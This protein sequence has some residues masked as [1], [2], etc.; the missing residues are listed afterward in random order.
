[1]K[2]NNAI[3]KSFF[4]TGDYPTEAQFIDLIDSF[5]N[6]EEEDAVTGILENGNGTFTFQLLSG[7]QVTLNGATLPE[8]IP[9]ANIIGLQALLD[10]SAPGNFLAKDQDQNTTGSLSIDMAAFGDDKSFVINAQGVTVYLTMDTNGNAVM[11]NVSTNDGQN[12]KLVIKKNG[13]IEFDD[14]GTTHTLWHSGNDGNGSG[15]D[16][17][18]LDG[19]EGANLLRSDSNDSYNG[20]VLTMGFGNKSRIDFL[21]ITAPDQSIS[22]EYEAADGSLLES[23]YA[24]KIKSQNNTP[25]DKAHLEVEGG[26]Y[27]NHFSINNSSTKITETSNDAVRLTTPTGYLELGSKNTSHCHFYTDRSNFYFNKELRIDSGKIGSYNEDLILTR[28]GSS[29]DRLRVTTTYCIS[30][31]DF[32]IYGRSAQAL[33]IRASSN[34]ANTACYARFENADGSN[35]GY[36]GYGSSS[37]SNLYLYN[38]E[39][40]DSFLVLKT[41]GE[42]EFNNNVRADNFILS[43]DKRLKD[44]IKPIKSKK[45]DANWVSFDMKGEQRFGVVAQELEE[46]HPEFVKTDEEGFKSVAYIDLLVAKNAELEERIEKLENLIKN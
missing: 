44:N 19:I 5:L 2:K 37:N 28:A 14:N 4:E 36:I 23:G 39:G 8:D 3:L 1:M 13:E 9:I 17:D 45:I 31:Q 32:L 26:V 24:F 35:R 16:A 29:Q 34:N 18:K 43:S 38:S 41:N 12:S 27:A 7:G 30:D 33:S 20:Q 21:N 6:I 10:A 25:Q 42:A 22:L 46:V 15:L 40:T 11:G